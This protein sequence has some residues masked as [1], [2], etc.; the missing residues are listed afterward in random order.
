MSLYLSVSSAVYSGRSIG[1]TVHI[2][3]HPAEMERL[4]FF[5]SQALSLLQFA[6]SQR[7]A[8]EVG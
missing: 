4:G 5:W 2:S 8:G 3:G 6:A 1:V 7:Q